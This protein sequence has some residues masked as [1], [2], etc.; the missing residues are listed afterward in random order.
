M[1]D[2]LAVV[3]LGLIWSCA[4]HPLLKRLGKE[5]LSRIAR[6]VAD[7]GQGGK[8]TLKKVMLQALPPAERACQGEYRKLDP[9]YALLEGEELE[10][11][12]TNI[13]LKGQLDLSQVRQHSLE[14]SQKII[15]C[16]WPVCSA[17]R[18]VKPASTQPWFSPQNRQGKSSDQ[19]RRST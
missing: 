18:G 3:A 17:A 7:L 13:V 8:F 16:R 19:R 2:D 9:D 6:S 14:H 5:E 1:G 11:I 12:K 10:M 15:V 4:A